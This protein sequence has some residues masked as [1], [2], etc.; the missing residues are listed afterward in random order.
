MAASR[1][2]SSHELDAPPWLRVESTLMATASTIRRV[3]DQRF[4][5]LGLNLSQASLL[6]YV[7]D[8]GPATQTRIAER[9]DIGRAATGSI[10][11]QLEERG[12]VERQ[13]DADDRRVWLVAPT[14]AGHD[15][16]VKIIEIDTVFRS[17]L[18][19]GISRAERQQLAS[20]LVRLQMNL[21]LNDLDQNFNKE[22]VRN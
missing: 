5:A 20:L 22:P 9:L 19:K 4:A 21:A 16:V 8:F 18:R 3:Y 11:D 15:L 14:V 17:E 12:L 10:V 6:A 7:D 13:P 2:R 1:E